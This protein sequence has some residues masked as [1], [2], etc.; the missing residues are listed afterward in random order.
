MCVLRRRNRNERA[1]SS[2]REH[3]VISHLQRKTLFF[4]LGNFANGEEE[5]SRTCENPFYSIDPLPRAS[6]EKKSASHRNVIAMVFFEHKIMADILPTTFCSGLKP[7]L[8]EFKPF[9]S[10]AILGTFSINFQPTL[11][12]RYRLIIGI[13]DGLSLVRVTLLGKINPFPW[14]T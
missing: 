2:L 6:L 1:C 12:N 11:W 5:I 8:T 10:P 13:T 4:L 3:K 9:C 7:P 14:L